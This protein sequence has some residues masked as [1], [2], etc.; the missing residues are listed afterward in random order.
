MKEYHKIQTIFKRDPETKFK[1]LLKGEYSTPEL[2]YLSTN[3]WVWTEK[4]DGTNIRVIWDGND[5]SFAGKTDRA[6][7]PTNLLL[8][9][10]KRFLPYMLEDKFGKDGDVCLYG[11]GYGVKIQKGGG[12]YLPAHAD[13]I[14]FDCKIGPW[15]MDRAALVDIAST[16]GIGIVPIVGEGTLLEAIEFCKEGYTSLIAEEREYMAEGLVL[17]PEIELTTRSGQRIISKI[18][19][20]DF[21]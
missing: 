14:L 17:K 12:R 1:T 11:E 20:K 19:Y 2:E 10:N 9:L 5:V 8:T 21:Q 6:Q 13:F 18:K 15:W 7:I 4:I 16:L 3:N